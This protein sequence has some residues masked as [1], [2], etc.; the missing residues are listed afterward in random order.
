MIARDGSKIVGNAGVFPFETV[1]PGGA[2]VPTAGLTR[3]GVLP[4]H[5]RRGALTGMMAEHLRQ[6]AER[7]E[8]IASL[9]AAEAAI[10]GRFGYGLAALA[11]SIRLPTARSAFCGPLSLA[12]H[13]EILQG[14]PFVAEAK[15]A[16][17]RCLTRVGMLVRGD[18]YW[19]VMYDGHVETDPTINE[20]GVVH[21]D[22]RGRPDGF[23]RWKTV[24]RDQWD[25]KP[26]QIEV[27][28]LFGASAEVEA[29]L[30][31]FLCDLDL[32]EELVSDCRPLDDP[33]RSRLVDARALHVTEVWDEQWI[34]LVDVAGALGARSYA[35]DETVVVEVPE[36]RFLPENVGRYEIGNGGCRRV[37]RAAELVVPI[38]SL[39]AVSLGGTS[40]A[41]LAAAGRLVERKRGAIGRADRM[42]HSALAPWCGTPF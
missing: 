32:V 37:R 7:G 15:R 22:D 30:W 35:T 9:R 13:F 31:R 33:L 39:G 2:T 3:V 26:A 16:Y 8:P 34:R 36:D 42:F 29:G 23:T 6:A 5:R 18:W 19:E 38:D 20:W 41:E 24:D 1:L 4:T 12:G 11:C 40:F 10:Y 25:A 17:A 21:Y 14:P 27:P 28:D